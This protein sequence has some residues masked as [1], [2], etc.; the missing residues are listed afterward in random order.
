MK[1]DVFNNAN[2]L[3]RPEVDAS[4]KEI[5]ARNNFVSSANKVKLMIISDKNLE[6]EE[7]VPEKK[8]HLSSFQLPLVQ[9]NNKIRSASKVNN[10]EDILSTS[11]RSDKYRRAHN[12]E[13]H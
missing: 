13:G 2:V 4:A 7:F 9:K 12:I 8:G 5:L 6:L 1:F 11:Q 10:Q 3:I